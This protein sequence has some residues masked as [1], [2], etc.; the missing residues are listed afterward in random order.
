MSQATGFLAMAPDVDTF[1]KDGKYCKNIAEDWKK[2]GLKLPES[3]QVKGLSA[4]N[5]SYRY[6]PYKSSAPF[7]MMPIGILNLDYHTNCDAKLSFCVYF[8]IKLN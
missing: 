6:Y 8:L 2:R 5:L 3:I 4:F 7:N 1:K